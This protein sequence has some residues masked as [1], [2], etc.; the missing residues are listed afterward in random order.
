M[1][2]PPILLFTNFFKD[3]TIALCCCHMLLHAVSPSLPLSLRGNLLLLLSDAAGKSQEGLNFLGKY[4]EGLGCSL[5][6][7]RIQVLRGNKIKA[8]V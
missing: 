2:L 1:Y 7:L 8:V 6:S 5:L 4:T 3:T